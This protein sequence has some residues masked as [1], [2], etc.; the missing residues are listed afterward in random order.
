M[1]LVILRTTLKIRPDL[2]D[3]TRSVPFADFEAKERNSKHVTDSRAI[4]TGGSECK[5]AIFELEDLITQYLIE[6]DESEVAQG[7]PGCGITK[8][9]MA[10]YMS[11]SLPVDFSNSSNSF[12]GSKLSSQCYPTHLDEAS[13]GL[14]TQFEKSSPVSCSSESILDGVI[15]ARGRDLLSLARSFG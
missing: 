1:G 10:M 12:S 4:V 9:D 5:C 13:R 15:C 7:K 8:S 14:G 6:V 11:G 3:R 2:T